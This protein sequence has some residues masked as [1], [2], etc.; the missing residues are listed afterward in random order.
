MLWSPK[1]SNRLRVLLGEDDSIVGDMYEVGLVRLGWEVLR[2]A[3]GSEVIRRASLDAPD[4]ILL[5]MHMPGP[6]GS[7]VVAALKADQ[8]AGRIPILLLTN[9]DEHGDDVQRARRLGVLDVLQK[10]ATT[11]KCLSEA[12][13]HHL[14][15]VPTSRGLTS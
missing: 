4:V 11:P 1:M 7:V 3:T 6:S 15:Q 12:L 10:T 2:A 9:E 13:H 5:D 14:T 8:V